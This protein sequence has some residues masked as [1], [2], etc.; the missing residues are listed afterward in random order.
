LSTERVAELESANAEFE[1]ELE[2]Q[3][4]EAMDAIAQWEGTC[5]ELE[6]KVTYLESAETQASEVLI[7]TLRVEHKKRLCWIKLIVQDYDEDVAFEV[8]PGTRTED[9]H[10]LFNSFTM[11]S[12]EAMM[13]GIDQLK[14]LLHSCEETNKALEQSLDEQ[15]EKLG[16]STEEFSKLQ[17]LSADLDDSTGILQEKCATLEEE[18]SEERSRNGVLKIDLKSTK[19]QLE[20]NAASISRKEKEIS[21]QGT[22]M[23]SL[24]VQFLAIQDELSQATLNTEGAEKTIQSLRNE[25]ADATSNL[26]KFEELLE[27]TAA[28]KLEAE[29]GLKAQKELALARESNAIDNERTS[30]S[31]R[32]ECEVLR[33]ENGLLETELKSLNESLQVHVTDEVS[34]RAT[35]MATQAL[36][37]EMEQMRTHR[38]GSQGAI[39]DERRARLAAEQEASNLKSDLALVLRVTDEEG[40]ADEKIKSLIMKTSDGVQRKERQEIDGLRKSLGR[41]AQE[42]ESL[43]GAET[44]ALSRA[45]AAELQAS[46]CEQEVINAKSDVVFLTRSLEETHEAEAARVAS[47]EYRI[48][49]LEDDRDVVRRY[50]ADE[51]ETL[52]NELSHVCMEKDRILHSLKESEKANTALVYETSKDQEAEVTEHV[53][54]ELSKLRRSNARLL[55]A[56]TEEGVRTERRI[57]EAIAANASL[58]EA[59]VIVE[60]ELRVAAETALEN[61]KSQLEETRR[62]LVDEPTPSSTQTLSP[63]RLKTHLSQSREKSRKVEAENNALK[64]QLQEFESKSEAELANLTD[65]CRRAQASLL[66][67]EGEAKFGSAV[68]LEATRIH[69]LPSHKSSENWVVVEKNSDNIGAEAS[70][71]G[72]GPS[73]SEAY[74]FIDT[75]KAEIQEERQMYQEL[76]AEHDDLLALLAQQDLEKSSLN[77][78]LANAA[79]PRAVDAAIQ[80]AE[81]KAIQQF[82]KYVRLA[83]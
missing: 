58:V 74:D 27:Q 5:G 46:I 62:S 66:K 47:F 34:K 73:S 11:Q 69:S 33:A 30:V 51:I 48:C 2:Q 28:S 43:R 42:L 64:L 60:R 55:S 21:Q 68:N 77:Q 23:A 49:A 9:I 20:V 15:E 67:L 61:V 39:L 75:L 78:A 80:E 12:D 40:N 24:R 50:H 8:P 32:E 29:E 4:V 19:T 72:D 57:R 41:T 76:L 44:E 18:I 59:D 3:Q 36:R 82:G 52:R 37:V 7:G 35:E 71:I 17:S 83:A 81:E 10:D 54:N 45:A 25:L 26:L 38:D 79:G 14:K 16:K 56:A 63:D 1:T 53:E 22:E 70:L 13:S 65:E 6:T 31:L